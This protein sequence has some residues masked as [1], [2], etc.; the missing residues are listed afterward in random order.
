VRQRRELKHRP[1]GETRR[2]PIHPDLVMLLR[3]HLKRFGTGPGGRVFTLARGGIVTDRAYLAVFHAARAATFTQQEAASLLARHPLF[4]TARLRLAVLAAASLPSCF[5]LMR[6]SNA[7]ERT[8]PS[9]AC[10]R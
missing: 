2:V 7:R 3:G 1:P 10:A 6:S 4:N 8:A 5:L 9:P